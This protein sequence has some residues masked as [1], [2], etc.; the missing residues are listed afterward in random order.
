MQIQ[1]ARPRRP[2]ILLPRIIF[3]GLGKTEVTTLQ[4][5]PTCTFQAEVLALEGAAADAEFVG[6][7]LRQAVDAP[8]WS[9][10][11][12]PCILVGTRGEPLQTH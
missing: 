12:L 9:D 3:T 11:G 1:D 8:R 6:A 2:A 7:Q 5:V 10:H 4:V